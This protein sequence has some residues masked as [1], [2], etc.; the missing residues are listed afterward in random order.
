MNAFSFETV[1][2]ELN[3]H[4]QPSGSHTGLNLIYFTTMRIC[5]DL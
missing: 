1:C 5:E 3:C 4:S 2:K